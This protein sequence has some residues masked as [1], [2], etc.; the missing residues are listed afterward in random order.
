V[1]RLDL[2]KRLEEMG[3]M[4]IRHL[5]DGAVRFYTPV[6]ALDDTA[7]W[8]VFDRYLR[9]WNLYHP[10]AN[11]RSVSPPKAL[12]PSSTNGSSQVGGSPI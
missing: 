1:K 11:F 12:R 4:L 2:V 9:F 6:F 7:A 3:C 5:R 8:P 10:T